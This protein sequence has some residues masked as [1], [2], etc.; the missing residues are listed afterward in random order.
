M[1]LPK[2]IILFNSPLRKEL[3]SLLKYAEKALNERK[4]IWSPFVSAEL[5]EEVKN[6]F[7]NLHDITCLY[8]GGFP[9]AERKRICFV[10]AEEEITCIIQ[11]IY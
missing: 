8:D 9:S 3:E 1:H 5:I 11:S 4:L 10:M 6:K 7:N 2:D